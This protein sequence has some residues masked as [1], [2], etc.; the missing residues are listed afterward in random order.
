MK[1]IKAI[2]LRDFKSLFFSP[3]FFVVAFFCTAIWGT[4]FMRAVVQF[5]F[6]SSNPMQMGAGNLNIHFGL[7]VSLISLINIMFIFAIPAI[8]MRLVAEEKSQ[9]SYDLLLTAMTSRIIPPSAPTSHWY[10]PRG[11]CF[12]D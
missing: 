5:S 7:F 8:T 11:F 9:R 2:A 10:V 12:L 3:V 1:V 4:N 6:Q